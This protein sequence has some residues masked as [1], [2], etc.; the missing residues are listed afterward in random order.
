L[1]RGSWIHVSTFNVVVLFWMMGQSAEMSLAPETLVGF[2]GSY[3]KPQLE[4]F[5]SIEHLAVKSFVAFVEFGMV[6]SATETRGQRHAFT[7]E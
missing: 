7:K 1:F 4:Q 3:K 6:R 5:C 2:S